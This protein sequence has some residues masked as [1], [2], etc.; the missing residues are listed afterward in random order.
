MMSLVFYTTIRRFLNFGPTIFVVTLFK[1]L[2]KIIRLC[3]VCVDTGR[4]GYTGGRH[5]LELYRIIV[6]CTYYREI[7]SPNQKQKESV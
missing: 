5:H 2:K 1:G 6:V 7:P 4:R 3:H